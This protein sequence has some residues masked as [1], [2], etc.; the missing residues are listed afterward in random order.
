MKV[1]RIE[2]YHVAI[3]LPKPFYPAWIPGYP[4][5]VNR[6]TLLRLTTDDGVQG[7]AEEA[8]NAFS[9]ASHA[10]LSKQ[11]FTTRPLGTRSVAVRRG[12]HEGSRRQV[13]RKDRIRLGEVLDQDSR[14]VAMKRAFAEAMTIE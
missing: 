4:Q 11:A 13:H 2:L 7:L 5:T 6:F 8:R 1:D 3:P 12:R 10:A 14:R 9:V